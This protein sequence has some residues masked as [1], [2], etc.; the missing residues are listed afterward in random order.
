MDQNKA[1]KLPS[2]WENPYAPPEKK[3]REP[4]RFTGREL[5]AL[6]LGLALAA[7]W[8]AVFGV[9]KLLLMGP[10]GLG[11]AVFAAA[12]LAA[13]FACL[14][15]RARVDR[16]SALYLAA[17]G[18]LSLCCAI[19]WDQWLR[20]INSGLVLALCAAAVFRMAG[21]SR[22]SWREARLIP[23][24]AALV[25][26]ALFRH[27]DKP[28]RALSG[29]GEG[30]RKCLGQ[31]ALGLLAAVPL[32]AVVL[33]LL[34]SADAV[35]GAMFSAA[36]D[37]MRAAGLGGILWR[38]LR[39]AFVGLMFFSLLYFLIH[40]KPPEARTAGERRTPAAPFA[41]VLVLLDLVYLLFAVIQFA[42][43]FGGGETA[44]MEGGYA[45]YARSGFF[46]LV[47][48]AAINLAAALLTAT[49]P[50]SAPA[51]TPGEKRL[52]RIL[53]LLLLG[54]TAVIL[55]SAAWRMGLYIRAYGLSL[56]RSMTLWAMGLIALCL[57]AAGVKLLR[58]SF[59]FFPVLFAAGL[60]G[61][62]V[63][64]CVNI[65]A[66]IAD[67]NVDAFLSGRLES[68]DTDY[69]RRLSPD[70][71]PALLRLEAASGQD[72]HTDAF[73]ASVREQRSQTDWTRWNLSEWRYGD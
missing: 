25:V 62:I 48:V 18:V 52:L 69:L 27:L 4:V 66:R 54:L 23:E 40:E 53:G 31:A 42:Y 61:W 60:A 17:A 56:L 9:K 14:G 8:F 58:P 1:E 26:R 55:A 37:W 30:Q 35:F 10:P 28:F 2:G 29:A 65:D 33:S 38:V 51:A 7:L 39:T 47:A 36:G 49:L 20:L 15:R 21:R 64:S 5:L 59:R 57:I 19:Y 50:L 44:A 63:F 22:S 68:V 24:T 16:V 71:L 3:T 12:L 6:G 41:T 46:Q 72:L 11:T 34:I 73:L 45:Q 70:T 13:V 43:L 67:Y 32:L